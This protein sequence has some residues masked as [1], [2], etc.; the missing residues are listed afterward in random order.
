[1]REQ[2]NRYFFKLINL[3]DSYGY[4]IFHPE[5]PELPP[6]RISNECFD[7]EQQARFAAIGHIVLLEQGEG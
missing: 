1:M 2:H 5:Y 3:N 6:L 4:E 7:T